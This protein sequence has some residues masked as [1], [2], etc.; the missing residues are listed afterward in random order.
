MIAATLLQLAAFLRTSGSSL[1]AFLE[2]RCELLISSRVPIDE[3]KMLTHAFYN[4]IFSFPSS[5]PLV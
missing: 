5:A 4:V 2:T 1:L 3:E